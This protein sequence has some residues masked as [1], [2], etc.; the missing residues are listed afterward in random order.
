MIQRSE[1]LKN[2]EEMSEINS[3]LVFMRDT[4]VLDTEDRLVDHGRW[5][6]FSHCIDRLNSLESELSMSLS[7]APSSK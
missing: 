3:M 2:I 5:L 4:K 6:I 1:L 7:M